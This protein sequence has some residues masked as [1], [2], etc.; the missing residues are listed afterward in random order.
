ML[1][2]LGFG[3]SPFSICR[4]L[5]SHYVLMQKK[6]A[7]PV[8]RIFPIRALN[9]FMR[10]RPSWPDPLPKVLPPNTISLQSNSQSV[11]LEGGPNYSVLTVEKKALCKNVDSLIS[12]LIYFSSHSFSNL[13]EFTLASHQWRAIALMESSRGFLFWFQFCSGLWL[14]GK[15]PWV[16]RSFE[17]LITWYE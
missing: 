1:A 15:W 4:L 10:V 11:D 8:L 14:P 12:L 6:R 13:L 5:T 9:H 7:K 2:W 3:K 17:N 16:R